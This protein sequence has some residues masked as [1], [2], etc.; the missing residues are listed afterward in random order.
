MIKTQV[1]IFEGQDSAFA[2]PAQAR[3][4]GLTHRVAVIQQTFRPDSVDMYFDR[5]LWRCI[6]QFAE[7][8]GV[9]ASV[10]VR[11][12]NGEGELTP[13]DFLATHFTDPDCDPPAYI[14]VRE[15]DDL[16]LCIVTEYWT[17]IGGPKPYAD[18]YTYSVLS[19]EPLLAR[20]TT[21][22]GDDRNAASWSLKVQ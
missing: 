16:V 7:N 8:F 19:R 6:L 3:D 18:S 17:Q 13:E 11:L 21:W 5:S 1:N 20:L 2:A 9:C 22:L 12:Q 15:R 14:F 10:S 4:A